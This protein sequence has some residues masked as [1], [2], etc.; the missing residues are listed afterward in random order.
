[1]ELSYERRCWAEIDLDQLRENYRIIQAAAKDAAAIA[2]IKANAYG[3]GDLPVAKALA[4]LAP[5]FAVANFTEAM[6]LRR[7]EITQPVLVLGGSP[8]E[9]AAQLAAHSVAQCVFSL[10]YAQKLSHFAKMSGVCVPVHLKIDTGLGRLGFNAKHNFEAALQQ[11][12]AVCA[13]PGLD[14]VGLFTHFASSPG[15]SRAEREYTQAQF[16]LF[17]RMQHALQQNGIEFSTL[18]C[19]NSGGLINWPQF[20]MDAVRPG[21]LLYGLCPEQGCSLKGLAPVMQ[22][23]ATVSLVKEIGTGDSISYGATFTA[24]RPMRVATIAA[25]YADGY[26]RLLSGTGKIDLHGKTAPVLGRICMDQFVVD[27]THIPE[28][29][30]GSSATLLG[31][32]NA[33]SWDDAA[34]KCGT[35]SYELLCDVGARVPR[36]YYENGLPVNTAA[37]LTEETL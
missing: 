14:P 2:V 23:K 30:A 25:G 32:G 12:T 19:C 11:I 28:V 27:V 21:I 7:G 9:Q 34:D 3:H 5:G 20:H 31:A 16:D 36:V 24:G 22:L 35:I 18:H 37:Y 10:E 6:R 13:L 17:Q 8:P 4:T 29:R 33:D 15:R 26:P 1:M